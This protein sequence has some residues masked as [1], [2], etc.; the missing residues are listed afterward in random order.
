MNLNESIIDVQ[1]KKD[2]QEFSIRYRIK[3]GKNFS[4]SAIDMAKKN[5]YCLGYSGRKISLSR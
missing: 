2:T 1:R 4:D 3:K 5:V